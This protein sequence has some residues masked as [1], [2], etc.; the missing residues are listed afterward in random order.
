[1]IFT[2]E[3]PRYSSR[4]RCQYWMTSSDHRHVWRCCQH[5][6][7]RW[8]NIA[9]W[10][11]TC[12]HKDIQGQVPYIFFSSGNLRDDCNCRL[13][14]TITDHR[15]SIC[16]ACHINT[17]WKWYRMHIVARFGHNV[18]CRVIYFTTLPQG[19][20]QYE[21]PYAM[22]TYSLRRV[23]GGHTTS[24]IFCGFF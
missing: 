7:Y 22:V 5:C 15:I 12:R 20:P 3:L 18:H 1:M 10:L 23:C 13:F 6:S 9:R 11:T 21:R 17:G 2:L 4:S 8:L 16:G 24:L 14:A 19:R